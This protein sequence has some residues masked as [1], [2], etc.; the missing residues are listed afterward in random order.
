[1]NM[2]THSQQEVYLRQA[3]KA[4]RCNPHLINRQVNVSNGDGKLLLS[5]KVTSFFEKQMAQ[6]ALRKFDEFAVIE[7][8][9]QV[10]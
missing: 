5:G 3:E 7:N 4:L 9:L 8:S 6:E 1:M 10:G 2:I